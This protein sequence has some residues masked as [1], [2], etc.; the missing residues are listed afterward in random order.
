MSRTELLI[1]L[2][3]IAPLFGDKIGDY[4]LLIASPDV[5]P[6]LQISTSNT[7]N[8]SLIEF[9]WLGQE[10][11]RDLI[12]EFGKLQQASLYC[13]ALWITTDEY[14][15]FTDSDLKNIK[16]AA[17]S[18]FSCPFSSKSLQQ[19]WE[20]T[21]NT[22]YQLQL[23]IESQMVH[24]LDA[25]RKI[26]FHCPEYCT[27][28]VFEHQEAEYWFSLHGPLEFGQ[29]TVL[30]TGEMS[31]LTD[32]SGQFNAQSRFHLEGDLLFQGIPVVHRSHEE[33]S[34]SETLEQFERLATM[35]DFPVIASVINGEIQHLHSPIKGYNPFL[36]ELEQL[37]LKD[38][39]YRKIHEIGFG[40]HLSCKPLVYDNFLPNERYPGVHFGLG[41]GGATDFHLDLICSKIQVLAEMKVDGVILNLYS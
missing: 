15:H 18:L 6:Y 28:S 4:F 10:S 38:A 14:Q 12:E 8:C 37:F 30:P 22:N 9:I 17:I 25:A 7:S 19:I 35:R 3:D 29:Q 2:E 5:R 27:Q 16:I 13:S 33:V 41:L 23:K 32:P 31:V 36:K 11:R 34:L 39:G 40:T 24:I 21:K 1:S 26:H 20:I